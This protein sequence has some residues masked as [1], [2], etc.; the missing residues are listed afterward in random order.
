MIGCD[1]GSNTFRVVE[2]NCKTK[3][4][5]KEFEQI[6]KTAQDLYDS[7]TISKEAISR[8]ID[9]IKE[10]DKIFDF[11][12]K[13]VAAVATAALRIAKNSKDVLE[14]I[15]KETGL[16]FKIIDANDEAKYTQV[17]VEQRL[18]KE[19]ILHD[20]YLLIDIGGASTEVVLKN[21]SNTHLKSFDI[22]IV[23]MSEKYNNQKEMLKELTVIKEFIQNFKKPNILVAS[24]GTAT[25]LAAFSKGMDYKHYDYKRVNATMLD[26]NQI[27]KCLKKL[28]DMDIKNREKWVGV[29][30]DKLIIVGILLLKNIIKICNFKEIV[31]IDDSLR[32]GV[33]IS[34]C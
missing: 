26:I 30:R 33:A 32:E 15:K 34:E 3:E 18:R 11:K 25:T 28:L 16:E 29:S 12:N 14:I 31:V 19:N 5:I 9:A 20:N 23:T 10:A 8:V 24:G 1:L 27:D 22:G 6:V 2:I 13:K 21:N 4:R 17:A 7:K